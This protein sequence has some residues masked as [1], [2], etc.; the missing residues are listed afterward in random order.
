MWKHLREFF[1]EEEGISSVEYAILLAF[2]VVAL[3]LGVQGLRDQ[4]VAAFTRA[5]NC[6][7]PGGVCT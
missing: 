5:T 4:V 6:L 1:S 3:I 7:T 2:I